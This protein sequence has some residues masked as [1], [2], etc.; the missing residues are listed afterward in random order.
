M[1]DD[2][3]NITLALLEFQMCAELWNSL[4]SKQ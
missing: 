4:V 1:V 3:K 2:T